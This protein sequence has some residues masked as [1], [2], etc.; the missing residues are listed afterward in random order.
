MTSL[1]ARFRFTLALLAAVSPIFSLAGPV[2]SGKPATYPDWWFERDVIPRLDP[3]NETPV[4]P[5]DYPAADDYATV[6]QGQV[7]HVAK[8]AY[9]E[10]VAAMPGGAGTVLE[11]IWAEPAASTDDY[12]ATNIGQLKAVAKPFYDRLIEKEVV[13]QYP[14]GAGTDDYA[15]AN[16]G[17]LKHLF[18]FTATSIDEQE[19][20]YIAIV[21]GNSQVGPGGSVLSQ[22]LV[23]RVLD[24]QGLPVSGVPVSFVVTTGAGILGA[25]GTA[26][27]QVVDSGISGLASVNL[28]VN[29]SV[30]SVNKVTASVS[31]QSAVFAEYVGGS[32]GSNPGGATPPS[33]PSGGSPN[34]GGIALPVVVDNPP[35]VINAPGSVWISVRP[36]LSGAGDD[37]TKIYIHWS[38]S[39]S[40]NATGY[41]IE[42]SE[43]GKE[44]AVIGTAGSS[45]AQESDDVDAGVRYAYRIR[46]IS[47]SIVSSPSGEAYYQVA[48]YKGYKYVRATASGSKSVYGEYDDPSAPRK[49]YLKET[50]AWDF[51][52]SYSDNGTNWSSSSSGNSSLEKFVRHVPDPHPE[53]GYLGFTQVYGGTYSS[54]STW[55]ET[56]WSEEYGSGGYTDTSSG[57][58]SQDT[59]GVWTIHYTYNGQDG[60][61]SEYEPGWAPM[62]YN[63]G[64]EYTAI[65]STK[66]VRGYN[67]SA[68]GQRNSSNGTY[69]QTLSEEYSTTAFIADV[70]ASYGEYPDW[71]TPNYGY[72][73]A[74]RSL[75][76]DEN[77]YFISKAKYKMLANSSGSA[78]GPIKW[79]EI[80]VEDYNSDA[81]LSEKDRTKVRRV[82][83]WSPA[84]ASESSEY[85]MDGAAESKNGHY[86]IS[87]APALEVDAPPFYDYDHTEKQNGIQIVPGDPTGATFSVPRNL[88]PGSTYTLTWSGGGNFEVLGYNPT[89]SQLAKLTSGINYTYGQDG[90]GWFSVISI[91]GSYEAQLNVTLTYKGPDGTTISTD[92]AKFVCHFPVSL[93]FPADDSSGAKYRKIAL[94]GSALSDSKPQQTEETDQEA[95]E[96][97]IDAMTLGLRHSTTDVYVPVARSDLALSVRRNATSEVWS[98]RS[99]LRPHERPDLPFGLGWGSNLTPSVKITT[100]AKGVTYA[101]VTDE[102]GSTFRFLQ[103]Q[104]SNY[105]THF[106]PFPS[107]KTEQASYQTSLGYEEDE[108]G[109]T[110]GLVFR[111][112]FGTT[113]YFQGT[114]IYQSLPGDRSLGSGGNEYSYYYRVYS[115]TDRAGQKLIYTYDDYSDDDDYYY[116]Y[117]S[118]LIPSTIYVE[119][120][121][122]QQ[123]RL[124]KNA[125]GLVTSIWD[126]RG[127]ETQFAYATQTL[128]SGDTVRSLTQVTS[129]DGKITHYTYDYAEEADQTPTQPDLSDP[130]TTHLHWD[131]ATITDPNNQTYTF[132]YQFDHGPGTR[133][134]YN[135][136]YDS[137]YPS[138]NGYYVT[139]GHT[140]QVREVE[141]P[142]NQGTTTFEDFS[143][144]KLE[145]DAAG[146]SRL[147]TDSLRKT[148]VTDTEGNLRTYTWTNPAVFELNTPPTVAI[149][150]KMAYYRTMTVQ[151]GALGQ[152]VFTFN[153]KAGL[154]LASVTDFSGNATSY[155]YD[156]TWTAPDPFRTLVPSSSG[157]FGSYEDPTSQ[158]NALNKTKHFTYGDHRIMTSSTDELGVKTQWTV[159]SLGRRTEEQVFP[160]NSTTAIQRTVFTYGNATFPNFMTKKTVEKLA[161][162]TDDPTWVKDLVTLYVPD[163]NGR[164][165]Q[166]AVDM[167]EN[168][169]VDIGTD[170]ITAS[171]YDA[172]GNKLT[173]TDPRGNVATFSYDKRNRLTHVTYAD[174]HQKR[175]YYDDRGN[176]VKE[177][178]ENNVATLWEY[179]ALNR[180]TRQAVDMNG[181]GAIDPSADIVTSFTYN[182]LNAKL[183]TVNPNGTTTK[184]DYDALQRLTTKTDDYSDP[185]TGHFNYVTTYEY[186]TNS[187]GSVFDS[188]GFKPTKVTD[189]RNYIT[190]VTYDDLYRP[191]EE[192]VQYGTGAYAIT[193]KIYDD[194]GNLI[195]V[196]APAATVNGELQVTG[197]ITKTVYDDLRRPTSVTEAF[198]LSGLEAT[199]TKAYTSTGLA[200]KTTDALNRITISEYD[201]AGRPVKAYAPAV[202][203]ALTTATTLVTPVTETRYDEASNVTAVINPL[204][205][206]TDY[207]YDSRNRR[208]EEKLPSVTDATTGTASRPIRTT[209]YDGVGN[210]IA[211]QDAR[212]FIT[213][214]DYDN[215]RRPWKV[216]APPM[217]LANGTTV[218]PETSSTYD[219]AGNVLTLT[220]ANGHVTTNTY[221]ALNRLKTS[222][223]KPDLTNPAHDILVR[224]E[225]DAAGNRTAV[226]DGKSQRTEFTYDG[227]NRSLTVKDLADHVLTNTYDALNKIAS[228]DPRG[229]KTSYLYDARHRFTDLVYENDEIHVDRTEDNR[230]YIYDLAGQLLTVTEPNKP[231][232][233]ADVAYTYDALGRQTTETSGG[234][235]H[236][237]T[238]DLANNRVKVTYGGTG[239]VLTST[240]DAHNRLQTLSEQPSSGS[241]RV[242]SY[243]YD[244]NGNRVLLALPNGEE[245]DTQYDPLNRAVAITTSK[246]SGALLLQL[247]QTYDPVSNLTGLTERHYGS[248]LAPRTVTNTYDAVNRL[249]VE[250][251]A[252]TGSTPKTI[253]TT[254]GFDPANNRTAKAVATTTGS[255]TTLVETTYTYNGL[256]QLEGMFEGATVTSYT[257][258]DNGNRATRMVGGHM[259]SYDYDYQNRLI[260]LGKGTAGGAGTY[261][262]TYDY[263]TRRVERT[264]AGVVTK[265]VFSGGVSVS[266]YTAVTLSPLAYGLSPDVEYIRGSDWGGG[267]GGLLYSVRS[268]VPS[269]KH[270]NSRGDVISATDATGA[271]TWQGTY[272]AYGT[273]TQ[274]AG[275]TADRQKANTKEEDPTGLLN[276][277]FRY[278]DLETGVFITRDPLGFVDGPNMYAYVVQNPWSKFDPNGLQANDYEDPGQAKFDSTIGDQT[279]QL[280]AISPTPPT[281]SSRDI[282]QSQSEPQRPGAVHRFLSGMEPV[283]LAATDLTAPLT[284][285]FWRN[286]SETALSVGGLI[287]NP[288]QH[289]PKTVSFVNGIADRWQNDTAGAAG[290]LTFTL[291]LFIGTKRPAE[292][293]S[294][295]RPYIRQWVQQEVKAAAPRAADG[296]FIDPNTMLPTD[297]PVFG[298]KPGYE[299]WRLK[300]A[301]ELERVSQKVFNETLNNP[302]FYQ[303]EDKLSNASHLHEQR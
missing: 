106:F 17:Q 100:D 96:T 168:G 207:A 234:K 161:T 62:S 52:S 284:K 157:L 1:F 99:G 72:Y 225:Y 224:N 112:K 173:T 4:W 45:V 37:L 185:T 97:F 35:D 160:V 80:F 31:G 94:N 6:N 88:L 42:R 174:A 151:Y 108:W 79:A 248:S 169:T 129:P 12:A 178:D 237:Y 14:W 2:P 212:G 23:V 292:T 297:S 138:L 15:L 103:W 50:T 83:S 300:K 89:T 241:S 125:Q 51:G 25:G 214:T 266:E 8:Q 145:N 196:T 206:R 199:S 132:S 223:Q 229:Q 159:D 245:T 263:R 9:E 82:R 117:G 177:T 68:S 282:S 231:G 189:P 41:I 204:G 155:T 73:M 232:N 152:E 262:Y 264:E 250:V 95:E 13:T 226:I 190:E 67:H 81:P 278:R 209:A 134:K 171:A 119:G 201:Q 18:R 107:S 146:L 195:Q 279:P 246:A 179:D 299:F 75:T 154:A 136:K 29:G 44:W 291:G 191:T 251:N 150:P 53:N 149:K 235:Q 34:P 104:D 127:N 102:N 140:R 116:Y 135:Y 78:A 30:G 221:D 301:A 249:K 281:Q 48:P 32:V 176:K 156:D 76:K 22:P 65:P 163:A 276:E 33:E 114:D 257:Y 21:S 255:G 289:D 126:P 164:V 253:A 273:R 275:T 215:A 28:T 110:Y 131:L 184:F 133:G 187:G 54:T 261:F 287:S 283:A 120:R 220:D 211:V 230:T 277:G 218:Y 55:T 57:N 293:P 98:R 101:Y 219:S 77:G 20:Y 259:D 258:D 46:K 113:I 26:T 74:E 121:P 166:E 239:T 122:S 86:Y 93:D 288:P 143:I 286:L 228:L 39:N 139:T 165:A 296:R 27:S 24:E 244:L 91:N 36:P 38:D 118:T 183:T 298:H 252:E 61:T 180:V 210:V 49:Y 193:S 238:Y 11:A 147:T 69:R 63:S 303:I 194:V 181:N 216:T 142:D 236:T 70:E 240:Y 7:K 124:R 111:K 162:A 3:Q 170:L 56:W 274:E 109:Y 182:K 71:G 256:N 243:G 16:I 254:Y 267:V 47:G 295:H 130:G 66:T 265:S 192:K 188:S 186:G 123:I 43:S 64:L 213:T 247:T 144:L 272:E 202:D 203:D 84:G 59:E 222:L 10:F 92:T 268:G 302:E 200:Y 58:G 217:T 5:T 205:A 285:T 172:N 270:Y 128:P 271:A 137:D 175:F 260:R 158:T 19:D 208:Y 60:G 167:N 280:K 85:E 40:G 294:L 198:G 227:L 141:L 105:A 87:I 290:E 269:F 153:E 197:T 233:K 115:V 90:F 242:T 148:Q